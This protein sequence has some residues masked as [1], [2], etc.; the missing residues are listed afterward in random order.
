MRKNALL[1]LGFGAASAAGAVWTSP[2]GPSADA[3]TTPGKAKPEVVELGR[4]LFM[5]PTVSRL[6]RHSCAACHDPESDFGDPR[7]NSID[8]SGPTKRHSQPLIDLAGDGFHWDGQFKT[9]RQLL[10]AR[11]APADMANKQARE[12]FAERRALALRVGETASVRTAN[13]P[14]PVPG[15]PPDAPS[16]GY[17]FVPETETPITPVADRLG[18][19][20]RYAES[21]RAAFGTTVPTT[22]HVLDALDAYCASIRSSTNAFDRFVAGD[23]AAL[24]VAAQRGLALFEGKA[25]C[26][27]CHLTKSDGGRAAFTDGKFHDTG[28]AYHSDPLWRDG[29]DGPAPSDMGRK[30]ATLRD[31]DSA[32]FKTPTLRDVALRGPFMHDGSFATL[33]EVVKYYSEGGTRNPTLDP[34]IRPLTLSDAEVSDLVEFLK[35][36]SGG[37]RAA[38]ATPPRHAA[39][40]HVRVEDLA[41]RSMSNLAITVSAFGDRFVGAED[42]D[43][44]TNVV[45][46]AKGE[47]SID[48][49]LTTHVALTNPDWQLGLSRPIPD[50]CE[51]QT[52]VATPRDLVSLRVRRTFDGPSLPDAIAVIPAATGGSAPMSGCAPT[53]PT[54]PVAT[55]LTKIRSLSPNE[56]LYAGKVPDRGETRR[57]ALVFDGGGIVFCDMALGGGASE[58][59]LVDAPPARRRGR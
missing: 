41:G 8:D 51:S 37:T 17:G 56:A 14:P 4:R 18:E 58:T 38:L 16:G 53:F 9:V 52:L 42:V 57:C 22:E 31:G 12:L 45:T 23:D 43:A 39:P 19:D 6:G 32:K 13:E 2:R 44:P 33:T 10:V 49:P 3:T 26:A 25:N 11:V 36:L 54:G 21:F 30:E 50:T 15:T 46:N 28:V 59:I 27:K 35:S 1:L 5:D 29:L 55:T 20:N 7:K 24:S 47:A 48:R 40:L 34:L